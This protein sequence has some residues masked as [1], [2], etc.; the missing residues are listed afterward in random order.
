MSENLELPNKIDC[1]NKK[2][3]RDKLRHAVKYGIIDKAKRCLYCGSR[4][5]IQGHHHEGY[6]KEN[7]LNVIWVCSKCHGKLHSG[8]NPNLRKKS[9]NTC[10][11]CGK[12]ARRLN[13]CETHRTRLRRYGN[14]FLTRVKIGS[15]WQ[16]VE[17]ADPVNIPQIGCKE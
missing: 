2:S 5:N 15:D 8:K 4:D 6:E 3:A 16:I 9:Q 1:K 10:I 12:P 11:V 14:P 17:D 13:L 7:H